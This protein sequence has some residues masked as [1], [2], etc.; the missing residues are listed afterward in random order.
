MSIWEIV[1]VGY[2][3]VLVAGL[4]GVLVN[5]CA[6]AWAM[7]TV[8]DEPDGGPDQD[9][10]GAELPSVSV[11]V[12]ARNEERSILDCVR[13]LLEQDYGGRFEVVVLDDQSEDGTVGAL[14]S[15][16]D[17]R[18]RVISGKPLPDGWV[19]KPWACHQLSEAA[20]GEYLL[21]TDADTV[22]EPAA[23]RAAVGWARRHG[24]GLLSLWPGQITRTWSERLVIP[25]LYVLGAG[26]LP[27]VIY[28]TF[29]RFPRSLRLV[30]ER[31]ARIMG[32]ANGQFMLF[33]GETYRAVGGHRAVKSDLVEDVALGRRT[34]LAAGMG[35]GGR[36]LNADGSPLV[37]CRMY[38]SFGELWA[39]FSKNVRPVFEDRPGGFVG[40][41]IFN[42]CALVVPVLALAFAYA[43]PWVLAEVGLIFAIRV[44]LTLRFRTSWWSVVGH[45]VAYLLAT[46]I[47]IN[48][49][50]LTRR[51]AVLWKGR[52]YDPL[53]TGNSSRRR[54]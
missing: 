37:R 31:G 8:G 50:R 39:G 41:G 33:Q 5:S 13:S 51:G 35:V 29:L 10:G 19:G 23:L 6:S 21:F 52:R 4:V 1:V 26:M 32:V 45:P 36:L 44:V 38:R 48:S 18:L 40:L 34:L 15:L 47:G 3:L 49:W 28:A 11:L 25:L 42:L 9:G 24:L 53:N 17:A 16:D 14:A 30:G 12:P 46:A 7:P 43:S 2:H 20:S 22:H 27:H 54:P